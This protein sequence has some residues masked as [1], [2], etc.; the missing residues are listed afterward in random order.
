MAAGQDNQS[1]GTPRALLTKRQMVLGQIPNLT[2]LISNTN[3]A[4]Q[5]G[6]TVWNCRN[7]LFQ[8]SFTKGSQRG[9]LL[10]VAFISFF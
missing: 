7:C 10:T 4:K 9:Y 8:L 6:W 1:P 3:F 2:F 5:L